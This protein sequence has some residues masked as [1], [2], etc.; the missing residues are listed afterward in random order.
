MS[1][2][3]L[4]QNERSK[5][6][7]RSQNENADSKKNEVLPAKRAA[8]GTLSTNNIRIQPSRAAK[9]YHMNMEL[10][11][12]LSETHF[13]LKDYENIGFTLQNYFI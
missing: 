13:V 7:K 12:V 5:L 6:V 8:L 1:N 2:N 10:K 4:N 9:V 3:A 11:I